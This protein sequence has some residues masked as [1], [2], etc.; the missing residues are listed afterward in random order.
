MCG[1]ST[2]F[3]NATENVTSCSSAR[4]AEKCESI[5]KGEGFFDREQPG[6]KSVS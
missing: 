6:N 3:C 2:V 4:Y 1:Y 5:Q